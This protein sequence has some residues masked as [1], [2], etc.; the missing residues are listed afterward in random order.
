MFINKRRNYASLVTVISS[1][2]GMLLSNPSVARQQYQENPKAQNVNWDF[3]GDV[4]IITYDLPAPLDAMFEVSAAVVKQGDPNYRVP[5]KS[6]TGDIGKGNFAGMNRQIRWEY[7]NDLPPDFT[8]GSEYTV[9]VEV[10]QITGGGSGLFGSPDFDAN[11]FGIDLTYFGSNYAINGYSRAY[12]SPAAVTISVAVIPNMALQVSYNNV[13]GNYDLIGP[14]TPAI[15]KLLQNGQRS[16]W[17][18]GNASSGFGY[19]LCF[20]FWQLRLGG[21]FVKY[22][23]RDTD[24]SPKDAFLLNG[25]L[26]FTPRAYIGV[27]S[28]LMDGTGLIEPGRVGKSISAEDQGVLRRDFPN[29]I[30]FVFRFGVDVF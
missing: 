18:H 8:G 28:V 12:L 26:Y 7:R 10:R 6:A 22:N 13:S 9:S 27:A 14:L 20:R 21:Q 16:L 30:I 2:L 5:V 3:R 15:Q 19:G 17:G 25:D 4:C 1:V 24:L 23:Q 11:R 29:P